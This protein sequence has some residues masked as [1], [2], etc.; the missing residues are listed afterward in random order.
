MIVSSFVAV[1]PIPRAAPYCGNKGALHGFFNSLRQDLA[2][3]GHK[4]VSITL[5]ILGGIKTKSTTELMKGFPVEKSNL[6]RE[7]LT[8][9][10]LP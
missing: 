9:V 6:K 2:L 10:L 8:N 1:V 5:C 4:G 3:Q 7:P